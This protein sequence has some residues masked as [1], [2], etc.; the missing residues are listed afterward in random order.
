MSL[1]DLGCMIRFE[2]IFRTRFQKIHSIV[3]DMYYIVDSIYK[4]ADK[5]G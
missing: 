3:N 4:Y 2:Q 1:E 5:S